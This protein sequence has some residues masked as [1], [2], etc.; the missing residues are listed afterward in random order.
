MVNHLTSNLPHP[1]FI[2]PQCRPSWLWLS[3]LSLI[4]LLHFQ[5][6][7]PT[8]ALLFLFISIDVPCVL[9]ENVCSCMLRE[10]AVHQIQPVICLQI[11]CSFILFGSL[12]NQCWVIF[13]YNSGL[14][15]CFSV[16]TLYIWKLFH[17]KQTSLRAVFCYLV[18][19]LT[20]KD[21]PVTCMN[22]S[23]HSLFCFTLNAVFWWSKVLNSNTVPFIAIFLYVFCLSLKRFFS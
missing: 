4:L 1:L 15:L 6:L 23:F 11:F 12:P 2:T 5:H 8:L 9:E 10:C 17:E 14:A 22:I 7:L 18:T 13:N 16:F 19:I 21:L 20:S 3:E